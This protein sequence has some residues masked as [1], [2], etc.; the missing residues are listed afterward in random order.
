[1]AAHKGRTKRT[2]EKHP[3][4]AGDDFTRAN[5]CSC[6]FSLVSTNIQMWVVLSLTLDYIK[7]SPLLSDGARKLRDCVKWVSLSLRVWNSPSLRWNRPG[8]ASGINHMLH[9]S[10]IKLWYAGS[11]RRCDLWTLHIATVARKKKGEAE[12]VSAMVRMSL[13]TCCA[14]RNITRVLIK[15]WTVCNYRFL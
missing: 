6:V 15:Y 8:Q 9:V 3:R 10:D 4:E 5:I 1:M 13:R 11:C 2:W 14:S 12:S 7:L